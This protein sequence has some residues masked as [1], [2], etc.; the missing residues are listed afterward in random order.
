MDLNFFNRFPHLTCRP[1]VSPEDDFSAGITIEADRVD[2]LRLRLF[3]AH[4]WD[5]D[6]WNGLVHYAQ[7][8]FSAFCHDISATTAEHSVHHQ[9][10]VAPVRFVWGGADQGQG[11]TAHFERL[12]IPCWF[13]LSRSIKRQ[14]VFVGDIASS[15]RVTVRVRGAESSGKRVAGKKIICLMCVGD[16]DLQCNEGLHSM[17]WTVCQLYI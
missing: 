3:T 7:A 1:E 5:L 13:T 12:L 8:L 9:G 17:C 4:G 16:V 2:R 11:I 6:G 14:N 10:L 15:F